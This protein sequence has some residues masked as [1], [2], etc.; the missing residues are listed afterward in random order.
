MQVGIDVKCM[1]TNFDGWSLSSFGE[2]FAKFWNEAPKF[3]T[4]IL[5]YALLCVIISSPL[6]WGKESGRSG[7]NDVSRLCVKATLISREKIRNKKRFQLQ[8]K[9]DCLII[10]KIG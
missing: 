7:T 10:K 2:N 3:C 1:H 5:H 8:L 4:K 9:E 6:S